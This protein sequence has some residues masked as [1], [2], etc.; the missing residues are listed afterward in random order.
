M[1]IVYFHSGN[2]FKE[3]ISVLLNGFLDLINYYQLLIF[4]AVEVLA[5]NLEKG[6]WNYFDVLLYTLLLVLSEPWQLSFLATSS[7]E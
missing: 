4:D 7:D 1:I 3:G 5:L 2:P 6:R